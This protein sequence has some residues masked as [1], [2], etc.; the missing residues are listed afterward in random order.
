MKETEKRKNDE[1]RHELGRW[2]KK[3]EDQ[4][5]EL[6]RLRQKLL[7]AHGGS[8]QIMRSTD[9]LMAQLAIVYGKRVQDDN[10]GEELGISLEVPMFSV[11]DILSRYEVHARRDPEKGIYVIG[12]APRE[13]DGR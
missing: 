1:M 13:G 6:K 10:T 2:K 4:E 8:L 3:A 7:E 5:K 12:A 11:D 9:A